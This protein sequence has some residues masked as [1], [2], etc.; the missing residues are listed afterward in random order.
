MFFLPKG[1]SIGIDDWEMER[2]EMEIR[3]QELEGEVKRFQRELDDS[4][5]EKDLEIFR[6]REENNTLLIT[7][8]NL[9]GLVEQLEVTEPSERPTRCMRTS[10]LR[11]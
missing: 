1:L 2:D 11:K 7:V 4:K 5:T 3:I 10:F 6:L 9:E 8:D